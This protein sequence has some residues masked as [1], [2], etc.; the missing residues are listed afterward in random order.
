MPSLFGDWTVLREWTRRGSAGAV[1]LS[2]YQQRAEAKSA[3]QQRT[4][5]R[6]LQHGSKAI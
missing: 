6:R 2:S 1:Q 3:E 4:I 5:R